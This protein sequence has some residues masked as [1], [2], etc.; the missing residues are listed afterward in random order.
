MSAQIL[1]AQ[2]LLSDSKIIKCKV[3]QASIVLKRIIDENKIGDIIMKIDVEGAEYEIFEDLIENYPEI[4]KKIKLITGEVHLGFNKLFDIV[5][6]AGFNVS[7]VTSYDSPLAT[8][9][10]VN[11]KNI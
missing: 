7:F 10:L 2:H 1:E 8:F 4:F 3:A 11:S 6:K 9:E 5:Q